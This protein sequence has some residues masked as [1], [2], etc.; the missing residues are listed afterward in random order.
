MEVAGDRCDARRKMFHRRRATARK[1]RSPTALNRILLSRCWPC[2][3]PPPWAVLSRPIINLSVD[4]HA[5]SRGDNSQAKLIN[6]CFSAPYMNIHYHLRRHYH[7]RAVRLCKCVWHSVT[8]P[9][10][11]NVVDEF[12]GILETTVQAVTSTRQQYCVCTP[13][14]GSLRW[15]MYEAARPL[16]FCTIKHKTAIPMYLHSVKRQK[17]KYCWTNLR[18]PLGVHD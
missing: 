12:C 8:P 17:G 11:K 7:L 5:Q 14:I 1:A 9:V 16:L 15:Y 3:P 18:Y 4:I 13:S 6:Y 2:S 10:S